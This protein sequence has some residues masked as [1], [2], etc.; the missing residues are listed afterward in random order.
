MGDCPNAILNICEKFV[1]VEKTVLDG[2]PKHL[3]SLNPPCS[4]SRLPSENKTHG[5][6]RAPTYGMHNL[7]LNTY[8]PWESSII[9]FQLPCVICPI[10]A[11]YSRLLSRSTQSP[12]KHNFQVTH[13]LNK[14]PCLS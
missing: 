9:T 4:S 3:L 10:R 11:L 5:N 6:C 12:V 7:A 14:F 1:M 2:G 13:R 8:V